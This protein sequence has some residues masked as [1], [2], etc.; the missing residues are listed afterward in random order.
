MLYIILGIIIVVFAWMQ[1]ASG[2]MQKYKRDASTQWVRIDDLLQTRSSYILNLLELLNDEEFEEKD[3]LAEI[4]DLEGGY[5]SSD[6]REVVSAQAE[7]VTPL[8]DRMIE[9][10]EQ[11]PKMRENEKIVS[12]V[13][14]LADL[15]KNIEMESE[16]YNYSIDHYNK[17]I[18][19][20]GVRLQVKAHGAT[21]LKGFHVRLNKGIS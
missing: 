18:E 19:M 21:H 6:D 10:L 9:A 5:S 11:K 20:P 12:L 7:A 13:N 1:A 4:H 3:L 8:L 2:R 14:E 16:R 17:H 15:E